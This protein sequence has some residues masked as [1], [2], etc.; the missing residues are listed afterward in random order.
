MRLLGRWALFPLHTGDLTIGPMTVTL[1]RA[2]NFSGAKR[3]TETLRIHVT[4]P[5][6]RGRPP[7]YATGDVGRF[8]VSADV[9]P[10]DVEQGESIAVHIQVSGRGNLPTTIVPPA[11]AG[12]RMALSGASRGARPDGRERFGGHRD[13]DFIVRILDAGSVD[14]GEIRIPFWD[15]EKKAY[16]MARAASGIVRAERPNPS[17]P[18][19]P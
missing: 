19:W 18:R 11:R 8:A 6:L 17:A 15:P 4:E 10:R 2:R 3:E 7:G 12:V 5:P 16:E 1:S 14:L 9:T 13:F